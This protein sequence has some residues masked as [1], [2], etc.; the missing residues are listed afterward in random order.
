M[1]NDFIFFLRLRT[2]RDFV[3]PAFDKCNIVRMHQY[4]SSRN[5]YLLSFRLQ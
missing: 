4:W 1:F 5:L 3:C 2:V